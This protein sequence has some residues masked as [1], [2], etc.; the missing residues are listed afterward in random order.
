MIHLNRDKSIGLNPTWWLRK[1]ARF[2]RSTCWNWTCKSPK[3]ANR[4]ESATN[5]QI[6]IN[7][8][9]NPNFT[10]RPFLTH[11]LP[12][13]GIVDVKDQPPSGHCSGWNYRQDGIS[14]QETGCWLPMPAAWHGRL[15]GLD[16]RLGLGPIYGPN[17]FVKTRERE[18]ESPIHPPTW[19]YPPPPSWG[20]GDPLF[21]GSILGFKK[22]FGA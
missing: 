17:L 2:E 12:N 3:S 16:P 18:R 20:P 10:G 11:F 7:R 21:G 4:A 13:F 8:Y 1:N 19:G 15:I 22:S 5:H 9:C 6:I 14:R